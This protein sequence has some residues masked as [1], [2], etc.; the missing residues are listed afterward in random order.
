MTVKIK[1]DFNLIKFISMFESLTKASVK[2]CFMQGEK[3]VFI[4]KEN[5]IGRALG[6]GG[7]NIKRLENT[8][9]K[10]IKIAEFNPDLLQFIK[11]LVYPLQV[12]D[13]KEEEGVVIITPPDSKTRGYL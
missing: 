9:K 2:D 10:K 3:L 8:F 5:Q 1:Y 13:I 4:V 7:S 12:K 6:K 11:N